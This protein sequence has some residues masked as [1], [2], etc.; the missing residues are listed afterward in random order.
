MYVGFVKTH[1]G[2]CGT[3]KVELGPLCTELSPTCPDAAKYL[4]WDVVHPTEAAFFVI[5]DFALKT[6]LRYLVAS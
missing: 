6:V 3:G 5:A 2:C 1:E 4:F